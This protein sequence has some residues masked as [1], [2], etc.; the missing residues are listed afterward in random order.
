M[1]KSFSSEPG[2]FRGDKFKDECGVFGIH[3][4]P[5]A[6]RLAYLGLYALQHRGQESAGIVTTSGEGMSIEKNM[7]KVAEVFDEQNLGSLKGENAIGH[8][9][10]STA[11]ESDLVNAQPILID[12]HRGQIALCHNGNLVNAATIRAELE[13]AGSIFLS[14]S[15]TEVILHLI[16]RSRQDHIVDATVDALSRMQG[17][18]SLVML[19]R[20][21]LIAVRDPRGFRPLSL[22][23][24]N[25]A[26]IVTSESC[27]L[28]LIYADLVRDIEPGELLKIDGS[29][30]SSVKPF[31]RADKSYCIFEHIYFARPDSIVFGRSVF[32]VRKRLGHEMARELEQPADIVIPVPDSGV[33]AA[34]GYSEESRIP[35]EFGLIRNH[36]VGRTF[37]EPRQSIRDFGVK[38]KLNP[39][40]SSI[41][42]KRVILVEDSIV[43][44]TTSRKI[45]RMLRQAG[46]GEIHMRIS[47]PPTISPCYY[48][49]DTPLKEE[50]I[51]SRKSVSEIREY[52]D[53]D[54]VRYLSH[55]GMLKAIGASSRDYCTAC[56]TER[57]PIE[58]LDAARAQLRLFDKAR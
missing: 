58:P 5:E 43:R 3:N 37:I 48:G 13:S 19:Y 28:D 1:R 52:I 35:L 45:V 15:D 40:R 11:G 12:C 10:Y 39:V 42:G 26:W 44:G 20:D 22:G 56:Y 54:T 7:G 2:S 27:A 31:P 30:L 34:L 46:A 49:I 24:I 21:K 16:A 18:Y 4:H 57:Y 29:G 51:A 6:A 25:N 8:V 55:E 32:D 33:Y 41:L 53:A 9:R 23:R 47:C 14:K 50:L 36:Y 38:V 17:A